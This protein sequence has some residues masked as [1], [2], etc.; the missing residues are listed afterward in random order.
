[1]RRL[2]Q[3]DR[4]RAVEEAVAD[5]IAA[6]APLP[7]ATRAAERVAAL[8]LAR[9]VDPGATALLA[10][11]VRRDPTYVRA[12]AELRARAASGRARLVDAETPLWQVASWTVRELASLGAASAAGASGDDVAIAGG[13]VGGAAMDDGGEA[14]CVADAADAD[15]A[16]GGTHAYDAAAPGGGATGEGG[17]ATDGDAQAWSG[18]DDAPA[19][20]GGASGEGGATTDGDAQASSGAGASTDDVALAGGSVGG[21]TNY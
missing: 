13:S 19:P 14:P 1:M 9:N 8:L 15:A 20:G 6:G 16:A 12:V 18:A 11:A 4:R 17:A 10:R 2:T 5:A 7:T 3:D 21:A